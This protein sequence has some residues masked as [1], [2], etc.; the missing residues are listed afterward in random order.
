MGGLR[1]GRPGGIGKEVIVVVELIAGN[2]TNKLACMS[3]L[4]VLRPLSR[5]ESHEVVELKLGRDAHP[6]RVHI[7]TRCLLESVYAGNHCAWLSAIIS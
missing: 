3:P 6:G 1:W 7:Q 5:F 4:E 2:C